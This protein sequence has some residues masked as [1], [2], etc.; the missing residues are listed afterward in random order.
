M[1]EPCSLF[2]DERCKALSP[3][4]LMP[5]EE[6]KSAFRCRPEAKRHKKDYL[7]T[8]RVHNKAP[9]P[10]EMGKA[11]NYIGKSIVRHRYLW[12]I[13]FFIVV[14]GFLDPNSF[15]HRY[16]IQCQNDDLRSEIQKYEERYATDTRELQELESDPEAIERVARVNLYM[17]TAD[18]DVYVINNNE[19]TSEN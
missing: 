7:C 6:A 15:W 4:S 12:V 11:F 10:F 18:E 13:V 9:P 5:P 1:R 19:V 3:F 2:N 14:V 8:R 16:E 17:K